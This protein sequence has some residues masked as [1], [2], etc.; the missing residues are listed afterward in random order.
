MAAAFGLEG[1]DVASCRDFPTE[2]GRSWRRI[3]TPYLMP[4]DVRV[5][6]VGLFVAE[7]SIAQ[8]L[9]TEEWAEDAYSLLSGIRASHLPLK[10]ARVGRHG[11]ATGAGLQFVTSIS[12]G[13][14]TNLQIEIC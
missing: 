13:S 10:N 4:A 5:T 12:H 3:I 9:V 2:V 7:T 8:A 14:H 6:E 11:H 1:D